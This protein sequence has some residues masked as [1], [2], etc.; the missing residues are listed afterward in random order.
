M[1]NCVPVFLI[2]GGH[3]HNFETILA[4]I[5]KQA[6]LPAARIAYIG[7]ANAE[8]K[9]FFMRTQESLLA[10]GAAQVRHIR[11]GSFG[12]QKLCQ[13]SDALFV[14]GGDVA[15]GM[16]VL[17]KAKALPLLRSLHQEGKIFIGV[18][19]GSIMLAKKW[20][21][22]PDDLDEEKVRLFSCLGIADVF[23][24]THDEPDWTELKTLLLR[25]MPGSI[26]LG[27]RSGSAVAVCGTAI[28]TI[29]GRVDKV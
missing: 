11:I 23:C 22:W 7:A 12:W 9:D 15:Q 29:A 20:L 4:D 10:A 19:A 27:L 13:E 2:A 16:A 21:F 14:S 25:V 1:S 8:N 18:S 6:K 3:W 24:D 26:G 28:T 5:F 17:R